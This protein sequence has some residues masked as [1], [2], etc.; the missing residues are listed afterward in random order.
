MTLAG[1]LLAALLLTTGCGGGGGEGGTET[2]SDNSAMVAA[3]KAEFA[4]VCSACHGP[5]GKG[6]PNLGKDITTSK[7][8]ASDT[9]EQLLAFIKEGRAA[10]HPDNTTGIPMPPKAG[11]PTLTDEKIMEIIAYMRS[12]HVEE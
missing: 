2:I 8:V 5:E 6:M 4:R 10:D 1:S 12:I 3:G 9:D 7:F 11:D